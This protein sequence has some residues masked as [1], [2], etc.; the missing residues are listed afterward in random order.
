MKTK[1][2]WGVGSAF[3][4]CKIFPVLFNPTR[5]RGGGGGGGKFGVQ[6]HNVFFLL[7]LLKVT[8]GIVPES[9]HLKFRSD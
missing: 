2:N 6:K 3:G 5:P 7:L 8:H 9:A 4:S 1:Q